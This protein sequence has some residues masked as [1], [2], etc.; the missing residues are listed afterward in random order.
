MYIAEGFCDYLSK[1]IQG[2]TLEEM[3]LKYLPEELKDECEQVVLAD[4]V[5]H[6]QETTVIDKLNFLDTAT[7]LE[8]CA[9]SEEFYIEVLK[10]YVAGNR[11]QGLKESF[12]A[13]DME[14]YRVHIHAVKSSSLTIGATELSAH[15]KMLEKA[16]ADK[17]W[18]FV[19]DNHESVLN[20]YMEILRRIEEALK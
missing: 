1:P 9:D 19:K 8:Y 10:E 15:A 4:E 14:N 20:E 2:R 6:E 13:V 11:I 12:A 17:D 5:E 18:E 16:A 7:G 3:I